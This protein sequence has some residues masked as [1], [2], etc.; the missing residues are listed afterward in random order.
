MTIALMKNMEKN[1][2]KVKI[3]KKNRA[4]G[5]AF[6]VRVRKNLENKGWIVDRWTNNIE[7]L[8]LVPAKAKWNNFTKSMM[9]GSGGFPD[10]IC[11]TQIK[12]LEG[13]EFRKILID[14]I[15]NKEPILYEVIGVE[16]KSN[17]YLDKI[18]KQKCQWYLDNNIFSKILIAS[19]HK[20]KNR[21]HIEY[22]D[23]NEKYGTR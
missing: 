23:F 22:E 12:E 7:F 1:I 11:L 9:M 17:G 10:F 2:N 4:R 16:V 8:T 19:K 5:K 20:I 13:K 21:I 14:E 18:E 6:E 15:K 3:G